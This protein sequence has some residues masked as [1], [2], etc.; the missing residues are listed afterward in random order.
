MLDRCEMDLVSHSAYYYLVFAIQVHERL[1]P[2][3]RNTTFYTK[4]ETIIKTQP[5]A[6]DTVAMRRT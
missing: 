6:K 2:C 1:L 5:P 3:E 4:G